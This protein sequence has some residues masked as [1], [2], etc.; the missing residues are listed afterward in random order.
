MRASQPSFGVLSLLIDLRSLVAEMSDSD[1]SSN[2]FSGDDENDG[3]GDDNDGMDY[4]EDSFESSDSTYHTSQEEDSSA[5]SSDDYSDEAPGGIYVNVPEES[6]EESDVSKPIDSIFAGMEEVDLDS[7]KVNLLGFYFFVL[8]P[9]QE[10]EEQE[11]VDQR[12]RNPDFFYV[13]YFTY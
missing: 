7:L 6:S 2:D 10:Q 13:G 8:T 3:E 1:V 11:K 12:E 9:G 4:D 5:D